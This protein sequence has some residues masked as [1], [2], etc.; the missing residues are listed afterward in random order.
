MKAEKEHFP[1][2]VV[3]VFKLFAR[4]SIYMAND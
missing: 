4:I 1:I 2:T 3:T